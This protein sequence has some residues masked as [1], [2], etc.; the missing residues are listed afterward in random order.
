MRSAHAFRA[1]YPAFHIGNLLGQFSAIGQRKVVA[2]S[3]ATDG[4]AFE[5]G[6]LLDAKKVGLIEV[7]WKEVTGK[8]SPLHTVL[9]AVVNE[10]KHVELALLLKGLSKR[11]SCQRGT[12]SGWA[13]TSNRGA[14]KSWISQATEAQPTDRCLEKVAT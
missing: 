8:L 12:Q 4:D 10:A 13:A 3:C 6:V 5:K 7:F 9:G 1:V 11:V 14:T 2:Y